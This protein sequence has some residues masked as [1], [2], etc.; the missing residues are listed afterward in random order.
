MKTKTTKLQNFISKIFLV[1][2]G[3]VGTLFFVWL[4][5]ILIQVIF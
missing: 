3:I 4:S 2:T 1:G 5:K